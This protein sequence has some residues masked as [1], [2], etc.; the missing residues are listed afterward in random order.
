MDILREVMDA[1]THAMFLTDAHGIVTHINT[2]AQERFGLAGQSS[3]SHKAGRLSTG[4]IVILADTAIG[5][6]DGELTPTDL[7]HLR[8]QERKL[9]S[10]DMVAAVGVYDDPNSDTVY[11]FIPGSDASVM[12]LRTVYHGLSISIEIGEREVSVTVDGAVYSIRYFLCIGQMVV[13]DGATHQVKFW[14]ERGYTAKKE[15]IGH[16]LRGG[17]FSAKSP[18]CQVD[19]VGHSYHRFLEGALFRQ[20][21]DQVLDGSSPGHRDQ[22]YDINGYT[23]V[24]SILP[25][26]AGKAPEGAIVKFRS[27]EDIRTTIQERNDAIRFAERSYRRAVSGAAQGRR[28]SRS[29]D[30]TF[31]PVS[32]PD[33]FQCNAGWN[34]RS[35]GKGWNRRGVGG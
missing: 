20:H 23:L 35:P 21:L 13:L 4:D 11:K 7:A 32:G 14:E 22:L 34:R 18:G 29:A 33:T 28:Y 2:Q 16:L 31:S 6:D 1:S 15:G 12:T 27:V 9:R 17:R 24:A 25:I 10:G 3:R 30:Q 19:I 8:I 26:P 5:A